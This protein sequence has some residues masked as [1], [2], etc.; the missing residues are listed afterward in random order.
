MRR[1]HLL[2]LAFALF[3]TANLVGCIPAQAQDSSSDA[4]GLNS[5]ATYHSGNFDSINLA[6]GRL[7]FHIP[8]YEDH[9]QRGKLNFTYSLD[10]SSP[11][12]WV[13][14]CYNNNTCP[15]LTGKYGITG[16]GLVNL[17]VAAGYRNRYLVDNGP[18]KQY[19]YESG[20]AEG[21]V[22][23]GPS[24]DFAGGAPLDGSG[25][26]VN[27]GLQF[28]TGL[29][30]PY[31]TDSNGNEMTQTTTIVGNEYIT[32]TTDMLGRT[33]TLTTGTT[34]NLGACPVTAVNTSIWVIPGPS[35]GVR[36]FTLCYSSV[37]IQTNLSPFG[38]R[39]YSAT[40]LLLTGVVLPD[41]AKWR[42]SYDSYGDITAI[43]LPTGGTISYAWTSTTDTCGGGFWVRTVTSRTVYDGT[44]SHTW[45]YG[46]PVGG[47]NSNSYT[48]TDPMNNAVRVCRRAEPD[49]VLFGDWCKSYAAQDGRKYLSEPSEPVPK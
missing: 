9:S 12:S 8:L 13:L 25:Y 46:F 27:G 31:V 22:L 4:V 15:W 40:P 26:S 45:N 19:Y 41:G 17:S 16:V 6:T 32:T 47:N 48:M 10:Y 21:S 36:Q 43:Y 3:I 1:F 30:S 38:Y 11:G 42:F 24:H 33:W 29:Y 34:S 14:Q 20:E 18:P 37:T 28:Q 44:T 35:G 39:E 23:F 5:Q 49:S 2:L 7:H